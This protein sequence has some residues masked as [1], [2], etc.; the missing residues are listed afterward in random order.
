MFRR[1]FAVQGL[2]GPWRSADGEAETEKNK[3]DIHFRSAERAG[4]SFPGDALPRHLHQGG[5]CHEDRPDRGQ[6]AGRQ[7]LF[8][9]ALSQLSEEKENPKHTF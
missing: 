6:S 7:S 9:L 2:S 8:T 3:N 1:R 5:D 4:E